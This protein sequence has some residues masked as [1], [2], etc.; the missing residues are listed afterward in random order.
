MDVRLSRALSPAHRQ[1]ARQAEI[2]T[3]LE[4]A[5]RDLGLQDHQ[6]C[7]RLTTAAGVVRL[8]RRFAGSDRPTDVLAFPTAALVPGSGFRLPPGGAASLGDIVIAIPV[9][10][11]QAD[12]LGSDP[13]EELR[14]LAVHG[15]LHLLGHDHHDREEAA[16]MTQA[17]RQLLARD[18]ARR[19]H[20]PPAVPALQPTA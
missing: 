16:R 3:L 9:A 10:L 5:L 17:T 1:Q 12:E 18:A 14:L 20:L 2:G 4:G 15:L 19:G 7:C 13:Q 6:V 8:N 11:E